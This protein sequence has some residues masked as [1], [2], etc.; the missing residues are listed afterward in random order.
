LGMTEP[1]ETGRSYRHGTL[2]AYSAAKCRCTH[3]RAAVA[4]Y[5][6]QRRAEGKD[7]PRTPRRW[8]TVDYIPRRWFRDQVIRPALKA[9]G[10][11]IDVKMHGL[12][13][14]HAS[15]LLAGGADL[16]VVKERLGHGSI[17]TTARYLHTLPEADTTALN[18]LAAVRQRTN[19]RETT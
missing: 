4:A 7:N 14:A 11:P 18:A 17:S 8:D 6:A 1:N 10:L 9:A 3:C 15:W 13:H 12:R 16:Q 5:R 2:S 19:K